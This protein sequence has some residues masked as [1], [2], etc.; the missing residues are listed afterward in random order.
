[1]K[2]FHIP[3]S[4]S[5]PIQSTGRGPGEVAELTF[6]LRATSVQFKKGHR[7]RIALAGADNGN[8]ARYPTEGNPTILVQHNA[9]FASHI[10]LP[11]QGA[12]KVGKR[13]APVC[14]GFHQV[15]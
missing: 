15:T 12:V 11:I 5:I 8:F 6:D 14:R 7:I 2:S 1:M 13:K 4:D 3:E 10:T 9:R